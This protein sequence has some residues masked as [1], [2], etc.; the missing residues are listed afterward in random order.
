M[1]RKPR[2]SQK[3]S[4][5]PLSSGPVSLSSSSSCSRSAACGKL[6]SPCC[7]SPIHADE[8][9]ARPAL[10]RPSCQPFALPAI[11]RSVRRRRRG[12]ILPPPKLV[13]SQKQFA[14]PAL[15]SAP[16][17]PRCRSAHPPHTI[18]SHQCPR[19]CAFMH[20]SVST[21]FAACALTRRCIYTFTF[22]Q[23]NPNSIN[24]ICFSQICQ[25]SRAC[26]AKSRLMW[27]VCASI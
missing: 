12:I 8:S 23:R 1:L 20:I 15:I 17:C 4:S 25:Q 3:T 2:T 14:M 26:R 9:R 27:T 24:S 16:F 11:L 21:S 18:R 6:Q 13:H 10:R 5:A 22:V 7:P 19:M